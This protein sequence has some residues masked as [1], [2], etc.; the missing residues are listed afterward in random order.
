MLDEKKIGIVKFANKLS[1]HSPFCFFW[2][3]WLGRK[4]LSLAWKIKLKLFYLKLEIYDASFR[5]L[6]NSQKGKDKEDTKGGGAFFCP[7][8]L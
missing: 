7:K 1:T 8:I 6:Q 4:W 3:K 2:N 5:K